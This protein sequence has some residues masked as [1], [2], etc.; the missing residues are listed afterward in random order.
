MISIASIAKINEEWINE[1]RNTV[2]LPASMRGRVDVIIIVLSLLIFF[3]DFDNF[4][5]EQ[6]Q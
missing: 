4:D 5:V 1:Y 6:F 2:Q 3:R